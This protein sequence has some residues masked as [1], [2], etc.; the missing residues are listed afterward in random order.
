[1][2]QARGGGWSFRFGVPRKEEYILF[3][4]LIAAFVITSS[5]PP[6]SFPSS[7][8]AG[9]K[10]TPRKLKRSPSTSLS[11]LFPAGRPRSRRGFGIVLGSTG[12]QERPFSGE[13]PP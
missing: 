11:P 7:C 4:T 3:L 9:R 13:R 2:P 12:V 5:G 6:P 1:M 10:P 8:K